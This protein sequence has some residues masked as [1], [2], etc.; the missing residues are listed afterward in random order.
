MNYTQQYRVPPGAL[1]DL[2]EMDA[3]TTGDFKSKKDAKD[4]LEH[5]A[6]RLEELQYL[7]HA[8]E[9]KSLLIV[10]QGRDAG[11]KDGTIKYV[12][13][14]MNP[15]GCVISNFKV[16]SREEAAH[17][18]LWRCHKAVPGKGQVAV[19]NRS[20][21]EDVLVVRVHK[22][23]PEEIWSKRYDHINA[24]ERLLTDHGTQILKFY[25]HIDGEEQLERFKD[26][27]DDPDRRWKISDADY[28]ERPLAPD[29]AAAY[30][31]AFARCSTDEA[32]WFVIP[33]NHKWFRNLAVGRIVVE[34]LEGM[35]LKTPQPT[36]DLEEIRRKYH[37][38]EKA[39]SR[40]KN[41]D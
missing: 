25:L 9:Q 40:K 34:A 32:P 12:L 13:G 31:D 3:G 18:F 41:D 35:N 39:A 24:F 20:H 37:A 19:F 26:R 11:G 21:Y 30:R 4:E 8:S 10:L 36:V 16:P 2:D 6:K 1:I 14:A 7:L 38:A 28:S 29:Y 23:V 27:L 17:D 33:S 22:L 15:Q 5:V